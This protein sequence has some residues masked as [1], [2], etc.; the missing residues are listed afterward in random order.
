MTSLAQA[1][2]RLEPTEDLFHSFAAPLAEPIAGVAGAASVDRA[3]GLLRVVWGDSMLTQCAHQ[4]FLIVTL[5]G[6][7]WPVIS[8][9]I[10]NAAVGSAMPLA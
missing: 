7:D 3:V 1:G 6:A 8:A 10:A 2:D 4:L 5:V 9:A